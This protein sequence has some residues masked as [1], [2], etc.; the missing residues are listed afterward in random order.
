MTR[1]ESDP[2]T[3]DRPQTDLYAFLGDL[4][5]FGSLMPPQVEGWAVDGDACSFRIK[6]MAA[7]GMRVA[8]RR[9]EDLVRFESHGKNPFAFALS[10]HLEP[11]GR[12]TVLRLVM[13]ADL[14]P[15]LKAMAA[16]PLKNFLNL[17]AGACLQAA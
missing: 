10:C 7:I 14:N 2:V 9:P 1:I 16:G 4:S 5:R 6:G 13:D 12:A 17:L 15:M 8:E 11:A 3:V